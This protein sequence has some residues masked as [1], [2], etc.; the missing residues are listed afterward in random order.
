MNGNWYHLYNLQKNVKNIHGGVLP[1]V[2][3]VPIPHGCFSSFFSVVQVVP[4]PAN[5]HLQVPGRFK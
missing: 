2:L 3:K 5:H 1:L 4:H